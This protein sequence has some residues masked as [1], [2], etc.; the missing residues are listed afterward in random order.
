MTRKHLPGP[1]D[2]AADWEVVG[3]PSR[4][5]GAAVSVRFDPADARAV[6]A[7]GRALGLTLSE[8]VRRA[9][10]MAAHDPS[11]LAAQQDPGARA[12]QLVN[13]QRAN[14]VWRP[15]DDLNAVVVSSTERPFPGGF[16]REE[17]AT[18][19]AVGP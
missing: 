2:D 13:G 7:A 11:L 17:A 14:I 1:A 16:G 4:P 15:S 18:L 3:G 9:A 8:F 10:L 12:H 5:L 6:R 19:T